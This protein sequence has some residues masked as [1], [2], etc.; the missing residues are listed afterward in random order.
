MFLKSNLTVS[1]DV[2]V[3]KKIKELHNF[4]VSASVE[5]HLRKVLEEKVGD[6]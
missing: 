5:E 1:V 3:L 6:L 2:D 4:N